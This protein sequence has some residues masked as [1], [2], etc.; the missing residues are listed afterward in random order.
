MKMPDVIAQKNTNTSYF[1][2]MVRKHL[3]LGVK[4]TRGRWIGQDSGVGHQYKL[5]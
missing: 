2:E 1:R 4:Y 5:Y 3:S